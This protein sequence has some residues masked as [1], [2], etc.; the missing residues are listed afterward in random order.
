[1]AEAWELLTHNEVI[2]MSLDHDLGDHEPSGKALVM[3]MVEGNKWPLYKPQVHSQNPYGRLVM[4]DL[5]ERYGP[6]DEGNKRTT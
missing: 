5:I 6:Y 1:V 2:Y 3:L 4:L